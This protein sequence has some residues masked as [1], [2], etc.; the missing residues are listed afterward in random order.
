MLKY[1]PDIMKSVENA[2]RRLVRSP[3]NPDKVSL[4]LLGGAAVMLA[5]AR[6]PS[7]DIDAMHAQELRRLGDAMQGLYI[8]TDATAC[9]HP[10][11]M[12]RVVPLRS[13]ENIDLFLLSPVDIVISKTARG[14]AKDIKDIYDSTMADGID[15]SEFEVLYTEGMDH[16]VGGTREGFLRNMEETKAVIR[17]RHLLNDAGILGIV[18][19]ELGRICASGEISGTVET[20]AIRY[21]ICGP[22]ERDELGKKPG[23][24]DS[25]EYLF[26][27]A[28][29]ALT[30]TRGE[31]NLIHLLRKH[32]RRS[33]PVP[34]QTRSLPGPNVNPA[35]LFKLFKTLAQCVM[36]RL[37]GDKID[38]LEDRHPS[39]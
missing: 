5:P 11:Y 28:G 36:S 1:A 38:Q 33:N 25:M 15:V 13:F 16:W 2:D 10:G 17:E 21:T 24:R 20:D 8:V 22:E 19:E 23:V 27:H 29:E 37:Q 26:L 31:T 14:Y 34:L 35:K 39:P 7:T 18:S 12:D 3:L 32:Y 9:L 6:R 4:V 30:D